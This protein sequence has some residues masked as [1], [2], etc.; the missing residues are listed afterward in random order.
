MRLSG[1]WQKP[2]PNSVW[3]NKWGPLSGGSPPLLPE[4][5]RAYPPQESYMY[6]PVTGTGDGTAPVVSLTFPYINRSHVKASVDGVLAVASWTGA[7]EVTFAAP[8]PVGSTW[9]VYRDTPTEPVV[10]FTNGSILTEDDLDMANRQTLY[11]QEEVEENYGLSA[12]AANAAAASEAAAAASETAAATSE[13]NAAA[14]ASAA[15]T[16]ETNAAA[17]ESAASA[18]ETAAAA[19]ASAA[20]TSETNAAASEAA[21]ATSEANA[22]TSETN[23]AAS[24]SA[25]AT[26]E[27]NAAA[28]AASA[29]ATVLRSDLAANTGSTLIGDIQTGTGAVARTVQDKLRDTLSVADFGAV[30]DGAVSAIDG[31]ISGTDD[32]AAIQAAITAAAVS[33]KQ[34]YVPA[35]LYRLTARITVPSR[36][37]IAADLPTAETSSSAGWKRPLGGTWFL[38]DHSDRGFYFRDDADPSQGKYYSE[39]NGGTYREQPV[40]GPGWAPNPH[41]EDFRIEQRVRFGFV[42]ALN[43]TSIALVRGPGVLTIDT[44]VGQPLGASGLNVEQSTD[45]QEW[46]DIHFWPY[47]SQEADVISY[48]M[49]N[50]TSVYV[51]RSDGLQI[52]T[53]FSWGYAWTLD[54]ADAVGAG[55]GMAAFH[56]NRL[57]SDKAGGGIRL[58]TNNYSSYG[59]IGSIVSNSDASVGGVGATVEVAGSVASNVDI[60]SMSVTRSHEEV[61]KASGAAHS[62]YVRPTKIEAWDRLAGGV[63]AFSAEDGATITLTTVPTFSAGTQYNSGVSGVINLPANLKTAKVPSGLPTVDS[64][65]YTPTLQNSTNVAGSTAYEAQWVRVGN[66]VTVSGRVDID[67]TAAGTISVMRMSLPVASNFSAANLAEAGGV[68]T[69]NSIAQSLAIAADPTN[70]MAQF[71]GVPSSTNNATYFFTFTYKVA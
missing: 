53:L 12:D 57:Y 1:G 19:S 46:K 29:D 63:A 16:S 14:S 11:R 42:F 39:V 47:W 27:A 65:T 64:G 4:Q 25:A 41:L 2:E 52:G 50:S 69:G 45:I 9:V 71:I 17:S 58:T 23:A 49:T 22:S 67:P 30:G 61:I 34:L 13:T 38:F 7:S 18:S 26:S 31:T 54:H 33:G 55:S 48:T 8:V 51:Q 66:V 62:I 56:I 44:L 68:A 20:S 5:K 15:S 59:T 6:S 40:P 36:V 35:G 24:A 10:D 60:S 43:P 3:T 28:S 37:H 21:A 70:D 32:T